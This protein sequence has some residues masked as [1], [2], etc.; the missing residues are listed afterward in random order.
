[1]ATFYRFIW[2]TNSYWLTVRWNK[3]LFSIWM[4]S[5][6]FFFLVVTFVELINSNQTLINFINWNIKSL[7]SFCS[8]SV[9]I[10]RE[11]STKMLFLMKSNNVCRVRISRFE[12]GSFVHRF[13][14]RWKKEE[15]KTEK[16]IRRRKKPYFIHN[17]NT[18]NKQISFF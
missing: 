14:A 3:F 4:K 8:Q 1:M 10:K 11:F 13:E 18:L 7:F 17:L 15:A 16:R 5:I 9:L 12:G 2:E 6:I